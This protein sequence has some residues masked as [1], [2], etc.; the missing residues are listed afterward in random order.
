LE[1]DHEVESV[2]AT[3]Q[4]GPRIVEMASALR[5]AIELREGK[6]ANVVFAAARHS[7]AKKI[8]EEATLPHDVQ[9][10]AK[11][12]A[13]HYSVWLPTAIPL[14]VTIILGAFAFMFYAGGLIGDSLATLW[15]TFVSPL[16]QSLTMMIFQN[17]FASR[18]L[19][20]GIDAGVLAALSVG[21]PYVLLF[22]VIL[23]VLEDTGYMTNISFISDSLMRKLGL[24]GR[25]V[26]PL[27][28]GLGC[29]VPAIMATRVLS[30]R[31]ERMLA[32]VLITLT[33]CSARIAVI[34]GVVAY[35]VGWQYAL[36][37]FLVDLIIIGLIGKALNLILPGEPSPL[38]MEMAPFR[39]PSWN[40]VMRKTWFRFK[41]FML[42]ALPLVTIGSLIMGLFYELGFFAIM[43]E[44]TGPAFNY[45][46]G[47]PAIAG[48]AFVL[49]ILRK[50]LTV[51]LLVALAVM[52]YGP[53]AHNLLFFMSPVQ[54]LVFALVVTIYFP[55]IATM[56]VL[57]KEIGWRNALGVVG[58]TSSLAV[59]VGAVAFR[60]AAVL[61]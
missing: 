10:E 26:I 32:S 1:D 56:G 23:S 41:A 13:S 51:Q 9:A 53:S 44:Y 21:L 24:Q 42:M 5:D 58:A 29:N 31:R 36:V 30:T 54:L 15:G 3:V 28:M 34:L 50:E 11:E 39:V 33:P 57:G 7:L 37:I 46:L 17:E 8:A 22:Y 43:T 47:L 27:I 12:L 18:V 20:W 4:N 49:G 19:L 61:L 52:Q 40:S 35:L 38:M 14:M 2:L 59:L 48:V 60:V 45:V 25:S 55:C 6:A 16:L